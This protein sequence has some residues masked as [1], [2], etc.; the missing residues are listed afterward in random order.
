MEVGEEPPRAWHTSLYC[1]HPPMFCLF[2]CFPQMLCWYQLSPKGPAP[3]APKNRKIR[4]IFRKGREMKTSQEAKWANRHLS[5]SENCLSFPA[6]GEF[7]I[8]R[9]RWGHRGQYSG[10]SFLQRSFGGWGYHLVV[11]C[12][13]CMC[14]ALVYSSPN[15]PNKNQNCCWHLV[16]QGYF[17]NYLSGA[18]K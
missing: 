5:R 15:I 16:V 12:V 13:P 18:R 8:P 1:C 2:F 6:K 10:S 11:E 17:P 4:D 14:K 3:K 7:G 9:V